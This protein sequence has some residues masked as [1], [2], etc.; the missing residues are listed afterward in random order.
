MA[1]LEERAIGGLV[2]RIDRLLCVGFEDCVVCAPTVF[3][4][5]EEG[6]ACFT[7]DAGGIDEATLI[8][9]CRVCPVD[10]LSASDLSGRQVAP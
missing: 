4:V 6:I 8:E 10:A 9:A 3:R 2:V 5:D 7:D 1:N